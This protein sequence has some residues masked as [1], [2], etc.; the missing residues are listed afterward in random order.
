M[1][2]RLDKGVTQLFDIAEQ[3]TGSV[4]TLMEQLTNLWEIIPDVRAAQRELGHLLT[5][6]HTGMTEVVKFEYRV[7]LEYQFYQLCE[8]LVW[9]LQ[10]YDFLYINKYSELRHMS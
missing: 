1:C 3:Q 4:N 6:I 8:C 9:N 5:Q 7:L 10:V 2:F